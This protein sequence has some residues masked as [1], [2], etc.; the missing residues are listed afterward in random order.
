MPEWLSNKNAIVNMKN[1]D[2]EC[3]KW[4]VTQSLF[5]SK[6]NAGRITKKLREDSKKLSWEGVEFPTPVWP[7]AYKKFE[8]NNN[9]GLSVYS[10]DEKGVYVV[11]N[12]ER[13]FPRVARLFLLR[14]EGEES[15]YC[16]VRDVSRLMS[17]QR[18]DR[19]K[20]AF[21]PYCNL[22]FASMKRE[23][24]DERGVRREDKV[25][26]AEQRLAD[27]VCTGVGVNTYSPLEVLP[28]KGES[29]LKITKY[30]VLFKCPLRC[31]ADFESALV[32]TY[33]T[34]GKVVKFHKHVP[35][36]FYLRFVSKIP[37]LR[38]KPIYYAGPNA[39]KKF[40]WHLHQVAAKIDCAFP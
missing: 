10:H 15:H 7:L 33:D 28:K 37:Q 30:N 32:K 34:S 3:F 21:C 17:S 2:N 26:S 16:V 35:V 1:K 4:A 11:R 12:P 40:V 24:V 13:L 20:V 25:V 5:P 38:F 36:A 6:K 19:R 31:Y 39:E 8:N 23:V 14:G 18:K 9:V 27:H 29:I 22:S